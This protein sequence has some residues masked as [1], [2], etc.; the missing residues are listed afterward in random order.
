MVP[1]RHFRAMRPSVSRRGGQSPRFRER[2]V[3]GTA[4][5]HGTGERIVG[6]LGLRCRLTSGHPPQGRP[7]PTLAGDGPK[8]QR[9][10]TQQLDKPP[11]LF[12][13]DGVLENCDARLRHV[14]GQ[15]IV[16]DGDVSEVVVLCS[17]LAE[18]SSWTALS[19]CSR[20]WY[21]AVMCLSSSLSFS[22]QV[23]L[24]CSLPCSTGC[25]A[26]TASL[27]TASLSIYS[28][29][30]CARTC[31]RTFPSR[32]F[33]RSVSVILQELPSWGCVVFVVGLLSILPEK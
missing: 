21:V 29:R 26:T 4:S 32:I 19:W 23:R 1:R 24:H 33:R 17:A 27:V 31:S 11:L 20:S 18:V 15:F 14:G 3:P 10:P 13:A 16:L 7:T 8:H 6:M 25:A 30:P 9:A 22:V 2:K 28:S 5:T 12:N